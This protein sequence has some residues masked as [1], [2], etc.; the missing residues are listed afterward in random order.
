[1][2]GAGHSDPRLGARM[3]H[4]ALL[5]GL[6][7]ISVIFLVV[8]LM[9]DAAPLIRDAEGVAIIGYTLAGVGALP[10]IVAMLVFRPRVPTR[11]SGEGE[12]DYWQRAFGPA[13]LTWTLAEAGGMI[14][15]V[16]ALVTGLWATLLLV[17]AAIACLV[18]LRPGVFE[19][20]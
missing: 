3:V 13:L 7:G 1:M 5:G 6:A 14:G 9:L 2:I 11:R 17:V 16:G 18:L 8:G 20:G 15:A 19:E 4:L 12:S 10:I